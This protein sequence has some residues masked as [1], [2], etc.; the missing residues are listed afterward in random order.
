MYHNMFNIIK[1]WENALLSMNTH[2]VL[3]YTRMHKIQTRVVHTTLPLLHTLSP[4][5]AE[6]AQDTWINFA[7]G[8]GIISPCNPN[9]CTH[10][11]IIWKPLCLNWFHKNALIQSG[12][13]TQRAFISTR[14]TFSQ[15][16]GRWTHPQTCYHLGCFV[17][18]IW[19]SWIKPWTVCPLG[20]GS[21]QEWRTLQSNQICMKQQPRS[22]AWHRWFHATFKWILER[23]I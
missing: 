22:P 9:I 2:T 21:C 5:F 18:L 20:F 6:L 13:S 4:Q 19:C 3:S 16:Q 17:P 8:L 23:A 11:S 1:S 15:S 7:Q 10:T 12:Q 14:T